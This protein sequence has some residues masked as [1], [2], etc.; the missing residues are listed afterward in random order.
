[1]AATPKPRAKGGGRKLDP[2]A[3]DDFALE[4]RLKI[5]NQ[6]QIV[7]QRKLKNAETI[8]KLMLR[9]HVERWIAGPIQTTF[10]RMLTDLSKSLAGQLVPMVK[11]GAVEEE[12]EI[13]IRDEHSTLIKSLKKKMKTALE[14][15]G[16]S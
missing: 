12:V 3:Q 16:S 1:M 15:S 6:K 5:E 4:R 10:V 7:L 11:G 2:E 13:Y 9:E 14:N 8:G